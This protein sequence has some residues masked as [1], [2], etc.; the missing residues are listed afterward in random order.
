MEMTFEQYIANPMGKNNAVMSAIARENQRAVYKAKFDNILLREKGLIDYKL[1]KDEKSNTYWVYIKV[2]SEVVK[3][4]YYDVVLKFYTDESVSEGGNNLF[5]YKVKFFS[6]DPAF[7]FT[8][9]HVFS[10]NNLFVKELSPRMSSEALKSPASEKNPSN[11]VGYV[12]T[13]YFAYL[14]MENRGL[15]KLSRFNGE[16]IPLNLVNLINQI[17]PADS[18][19]ARRQEEG[20]KVSKAKKITLDKSTFNKV[21]K[22]VGKDA[23]FSG[24]QVKTS[25]TIKSIKPKESIKSSK[26]SKITK[27]K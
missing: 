21:K 5:K 16:C 3:E 7:V 12:K 20:A 11:I 26:T 4:F 9:A 14:V 22:I 15:N 8:Y 2:P 25:N 18:K 10:K 27:R 13:L 6:N 23:N 24:I 17:E 1:Y 19:I